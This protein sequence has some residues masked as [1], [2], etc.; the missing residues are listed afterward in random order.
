M[1]KMQSGGWHYPKGRRSSSKAS[2]FHVAVV[3]AAVFCS[4]MHIHLVL[5]KVASIL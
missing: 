5:I 1:H 4:K 3:C 2:S